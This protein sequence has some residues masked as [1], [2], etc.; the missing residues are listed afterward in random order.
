LSKVPA[1]RFQ[2]A[3]E[4]I[5]ALRE[6]AQT[7]D[8]PSGEVPVDHQTAKIV[9]G[10]LSLK[11]AHVIPLVKP[12]MVLGR[13]PDCDV[14]LSEAEISRRHCRITCAEGEAFL[15]DLESTYG[16]CVNGSRVKYT[17]LYTGDRIELGGHMLELVSLPPRLGVQ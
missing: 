6:V 3:E 17:H 1:D 8:P 13:A 4:F 2:S 16:T 11:T 12:T 15:E 9:L 14:V 10:L 7:L 5:T